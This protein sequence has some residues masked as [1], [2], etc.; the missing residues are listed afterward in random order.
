MG[1]ISGLRDR[2]HHNNTGQH[3]V[4]SGKTR[5][6]EVTVVP[7][8]AMGMGAICDL[9]DFCGSWE[10][11]GRIWD[12][13]ARRELDID[14]SRQPLSTDEEPVPSVAYLIRG[15]DLW[16]GDCT[17]PRESLALAFVLASGVEAPAEWMAVDR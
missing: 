4:R 7:W 11:F 2:R 9:T 15:A 8:Y 14:I 10:G 6:Q 17:D 12:E 5:D 16:E 3:Q 13:C 1:Q